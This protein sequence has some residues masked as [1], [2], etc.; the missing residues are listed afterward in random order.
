M[1]LQQL[2][3][4]AFENKNVKNEYDKLEYEFTLI[5]ELLNMRKTSGLTQEEIAI[6]MG[7][8]RSNI[9]RLEKLGTKP[10]LETI[11]KY[12]KAC[13]FKMAFNFQPM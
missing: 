1:D 5:N 11:E 10:T 3:K 2:K 7:T 4:T 8:K 6:K 12:A 9:C 13:G